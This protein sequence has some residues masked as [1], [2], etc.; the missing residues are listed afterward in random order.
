[1]NSTLNRSEQGRP[2]VPSRINQNSSTA[3]AH[4]QDPPEFGILNNNMTQQSQDQLAQHGRVPSQSFGNNVPS[5]NTVKVKFS[6]PLRHSKR[7]DGN[8][9]PQINISNVD[10]SRESIKYQQQQEQWQR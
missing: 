8:S 9:K 6:E 1:M 3:F 4:V 2:H 7:P 5:Q 10:A